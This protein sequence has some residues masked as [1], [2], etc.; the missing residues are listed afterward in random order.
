MTYLG[1]DRHAKDVHGF[2]YGHCPFSTGNSPLRVAQRNP[3]SYPNHL[4][5]TARGYMGTDVMWGFKD[6]N[7]DNPYLGNY[8]KHKD[9]ECVDMYYEA[10]DKVSDYKKGGITSFFKAREI[11]E[12]VRRNEKQ[13]STQQMLTL[14]RTAIAP[15]LEHEVKVV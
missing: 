6:L 11:E 9:T 2:A 10:F 4:F 1:E 3:M 13:V 7:I 15:T 12:N 14:M 8:Y 5:N